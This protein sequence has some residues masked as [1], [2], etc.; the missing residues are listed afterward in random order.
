MITIQI[1]DPYQGS[2]TPELFEQAAQAVFTQQEISDELDLTIVVSSDEEILILNEQFMGISAPTD[3]LSFPSSEVD[4]DTGRPY[5]GDIIISFPQAANQAQ[6][7]GHSITAE[8]ELLAVHGIL[9]LIGYDHAEE[10]GK[11]EMWTHQ[12]EILFGLD[13]PLAM[14]A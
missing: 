6:Q 10:A 5:L 8:M 2:I 11:L 12:T 4:P 9:H 7:E 14:K 1:N 3:V 13:N